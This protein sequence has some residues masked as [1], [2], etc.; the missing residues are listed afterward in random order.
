V[1]KETLHHLVKRLIEKNPDDKGILEDRIYSS[2][3][4][5]NIRMTGV[6]PD[7]HA[8][9]REYQAEFEEAPPIK[10]ISSLEAVKSCNVVIVSTNQGEPFLET[11]HF[12]PGTLVYDI[13]IPTNCTDELIHNN[14]GIRVIFGGIAELPGH[15]KIGVIGLPLEK[16]FAYGC[17]SETLILG[18][19]NWQDHF[20]YG[21][22]STQQVELIGKMARSHGFHHILPQTTSVKI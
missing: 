9:W 18:F 4:F 6:I 3:F 13:S 2:R 10:V 16:G 21:P 22:I 14:K 11:C 19:E 17:I 15:E 7:Q 5:S 20:S 12:N 8:L 1:A